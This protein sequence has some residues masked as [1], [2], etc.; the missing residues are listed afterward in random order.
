MFSG[1]NKIK[2]P[3]ERKLLFLRFVSIFAGEGGIQILHFGSVPVDYPMR[4]PCEAIKEMF[5]HGVWYS[6]ACLGLET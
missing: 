2:T 6:R 3:G 4:H 5:R 1:L